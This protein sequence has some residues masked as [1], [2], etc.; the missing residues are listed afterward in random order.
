MT[1]E[2][3][4][5]IVNS[6]LNLP[7]CLHHHRV[8]NF[9]LFWLSVNARAKIVFS[10]EILQ[11]ALMQVLCILGDRLTRPMKELLTFLSDGLSDSSCSPTDATGWIGTN[12]RLRPVIVVGLYKSLRSHTVTVSYSWNTETTESLRHGAR[13]CKRLDQ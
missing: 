8:S 11:R 4:G 13:R 5:M 1:S 9:V 12:G 6:H 3:T 7:K 2:R 10:M